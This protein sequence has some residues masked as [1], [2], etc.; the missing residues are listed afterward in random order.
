MPRS[1]DYTARRLGTITKD[2]K[3]VICPKCGQRG[4]SRRLNFA[5]KGQPPRECDMV[6]HVKTLNTAVVPFWSVDESCHVAVPQ[7]L[8]P[9][10][11]KAE[12]RDAT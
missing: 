6:I 4:A 5:K 1:V 2:G 10:I 9:A 11:V 12:G 3:I 8:E 7:T